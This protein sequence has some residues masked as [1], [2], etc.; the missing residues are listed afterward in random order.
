MRFGSIYL[1]TNQQTGE[2]YVGQ[3]IKSV[4]QR[5]NAH[6]IAA[7]KPKFVVSKNIEKY[8]ADVFKVEEV[9]VAFDRDALNAA[10]R[11]I[12][13]DIAPVLNS[14]KGGAGM[15]VP[16]TEKLKQKLIQRTKELWANAEW[17]AQMVAKLKAT[18]RQEIPYEILKERGLR[19]SAK[20]WHGHVK[21]VKVSVGI[22]SSTA[23]TWQ[24][25]EI[26]AKRIEG[27][28][29]TRAKPEVKEKYRLANIGRVM[30]KEV[31]EKIARAKWKPVYCPELQISFL[32]QKHAADF[33]GVL[34]TSI[35]N[36]IKKKGKV[37]KQF[38]L[39]MVK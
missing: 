39:E 14:T 16:M 1:L 11:N 38:T 10:E 24:D 21:K 36:A 12:I 5:W 7:K 34:K 18:K 30:P 29:A 8:G 19:L 26:R 23:K 31:V 20:R 22:G 37:K 17:K 32:S 27:I 15:P 13:A 6:C 3:T 25:P 2:Q 9:F 4:K 35:N 33:L 28:R